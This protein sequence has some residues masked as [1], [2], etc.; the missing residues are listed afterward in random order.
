MQPS[1]GEHKTIISGHLCGHFHK[2]VY[3]AFKYVHMTKSQVTALEVLKRKAIMIITELP[4]ITKTECL[5]A[6]SQATH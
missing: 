4:V 3:Y 1:S 5:Q 6:F 2:P